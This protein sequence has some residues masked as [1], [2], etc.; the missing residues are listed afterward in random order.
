M[1]RPK[2]LIKWTLIAV[3]LVLLAMP[4]IVAAWFFV[5][6]WAT[7]GAPPAIVGGNT[8]TFGV[9]S[10]E[11]TTVL[12]TNFPVG[13][14]HLQIAATLASQG[15]VIEPSS[16]LPGRFIAT[17]GWGNGFPCQY[18][19]TAEWSVDANNRLEGISGNY[20]NACL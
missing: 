19:L 16:V 4:L 15:F 14:S 13:T 11:W 18:F 3:P 2:R 9:P 8:M 1:N 5:H 12:E 20:T 7:A 6:L 17:Y 10:P